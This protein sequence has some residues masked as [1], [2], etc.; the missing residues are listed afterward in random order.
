MSAP[1]LVLAGLMLLAAQAEG[2]VQGGATAAG[3]EAAPGD[4]IAGVLKDAPPSAAAPSTETQP[5]PA[6]A[7][8]DPHT[9]VDG[10]VLQVILGE[11]AVVHLDSKGAPLLDEVQTGRLTLAHPANTVTELYLPPAKG[12]VAVALD[13][14][15][16]KRTSVVKVWNGLSQPVEMRMVGLVLGGGEVLKPAPLGVCP[17]APG[18]VRAQGWPAPIVAVASRLRV[19][20]KDAPAD[21][22]CAKPK[23]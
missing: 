13:G 19:L 17:L 2:A 12:R 9:K 11:R 6:D 16:E 7:G 10:P 14:S 15:A 22:D 18:E 4:A 8:F 5:A 20:P 21:P 23:S 1:A 3:S